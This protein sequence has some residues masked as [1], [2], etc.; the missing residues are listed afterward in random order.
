MPVLTAGADLAPELLGGEEGE[1]LRGVA[2][3]DGGG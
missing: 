2:V 3:R 1:D